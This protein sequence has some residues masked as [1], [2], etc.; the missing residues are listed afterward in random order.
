MCGPFP[1]AGL[2]HRWL[3]TIQ[4]SFIERMGR[5]WRV[6]PGLVKQS[7]QRE[8]WE[9]RL[10]WRWARQAE[11]TEQYEHEPGSNKRVIGSRWE[12]FQTHSL[13]LSLPS[14]E[15]HVVVCDLTNVR[16]GLLSTEGHKEFES[17]LEGYVFVRGQQELW[18][19]GIKKV[20][21]VRMI[22]YQLWSHY[23]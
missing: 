15:Q 22:P 2:R 12:P 4:C 18:T 9:N 13:P 14:A 21:Q 17:S 10:A 8:R 1:K 7:R 20:N 23:V 3:G 11:I 19:S 6:D 5:V 16:C